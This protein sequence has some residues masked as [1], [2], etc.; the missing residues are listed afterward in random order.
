MLDKTIIFSNLR[1][2]L[3]RVSSS[4][5]IR[6]PQAADANPADDNEEPA[7]HRPIIKLDLGSILQ[8]HISA[9]KVSDKV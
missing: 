2:F 4:S 3:V 6:S 7:G 1:R 5:N 8:S 9:E